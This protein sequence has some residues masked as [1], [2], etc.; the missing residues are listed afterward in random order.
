MVMTMGDDEPETSGTE[1]M[2]NVTC[3]CGDYSI[4][5]SEAAPI[6]DFGAICPE[7]EN[8]FGWSTEPEGERTDG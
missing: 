5:V 7:C 3:G 6:Y 4:L 2:T 1:Q 8:H